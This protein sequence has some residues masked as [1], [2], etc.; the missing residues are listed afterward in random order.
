MWLILTDR[1]LFFVLNLFYTIDRHVVAPLTMVMFRST[2]L[3]LLLLLSFRPPESQGQEWPYYGAERAPWSVAMRLT[4]PPALV[5][6]SRTA[7][8]GLAS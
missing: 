2:L 3:I 4:S 7:Q 6:S 5:I 1:T 8:A